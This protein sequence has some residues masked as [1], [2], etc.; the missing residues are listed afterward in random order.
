MQ[1]I[2]SLRSCF[3]FYEYIPHYN[4]DVCHPR[5]TVVRGTHRPFLTQCWVILCKDYKKTKYS[6]GFQARLIYMEGE[7]KTLYLN[8]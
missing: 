6:L 7:K 4:Y 2:S 1:S 8:N 5:T 3:V